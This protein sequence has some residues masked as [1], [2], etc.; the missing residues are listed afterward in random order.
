V[1]GFWMDVCLVHKIIYVNK[2][3]AQ[4][5]LYVKFPEIYGKILFIRYSTVG[6]DSSRQT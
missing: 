2:F 6:I 4:N 1:F 3:M 5:N